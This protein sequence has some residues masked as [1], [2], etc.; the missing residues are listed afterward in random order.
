MRLIGIARLGADCELRYT[1][2]GTPVANFR[3]AFNYGQ[4]PAEGNR[5]STWV[6]FALW[7]ER[8]QKLAPYLTK[9]RELNLVAGDVHVETY[10]GRNGPG[11]RLCARVIELD[12]THGTPK[13]EPAAAPAAGQGAPAAKP[14][15]RPKSWTGFDDM[16]D[17]IP[18]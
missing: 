5:P 18:F 6:T 11:A 13:D 7:G 10:E 2:D 15:G 16:D 3:A 14:G 9:R 17:D 4:K 8:A 12:F 1:P